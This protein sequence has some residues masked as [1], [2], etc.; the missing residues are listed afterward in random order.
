MFVSGVVIGCRVNQDRLVSDFG[1]IHQTPFFHFLD[2][3]FLDPYGW[4]R[5]RWR[6]FVI[7]LLVSDGWTLNHDRF[8][9]KNRFVNHDSFRV[10]YV[11]SCAEI[12]V[13]SKVTVMSK[14]AITPGVTVLGFTGD[15]QNKREQKQNL[16]KE[17]QVRKFNMAT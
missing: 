14:V 9:Y 12:T 8:V 17:S 5:R 13:V 16:V 10:W 3:W 7:H 2:H 6:W 1:N 11:V 15:Q 4:W